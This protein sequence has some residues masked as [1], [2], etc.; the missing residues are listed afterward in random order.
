MRTNYGGI[1]I[2]HDVFK[3]GASAMAAKSR[4][5]TPS[6]DRREKRTKTLFQLPKKVGRSRH[7][8]PVRANQSTASLNKPVIRTGPAGIAALAR[9]MRL[10]P[11]PLMIF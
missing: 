5:Q 8:E 11:R 7:G 2:D 9:Q 6:L 3:V 4:S 1:D 10:H